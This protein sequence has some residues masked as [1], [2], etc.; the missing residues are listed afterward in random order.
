MSI[1]VMPRL[2][3]ARHLSFPGRFPLYCM[4]ND[5]RC[6]KAAPA[7]VSPGPL[8]LTR[9]TS[10]MAQRHVRFALPAESESSS[11]SSS[12]SIRNVERP[13]LGLSIPV[14]T[15]ICSQPSI[16]DYVSPASSSSTLVE[17][18]PMLRPPVKREAM[19]PSYQGLSAD[20]HSSLPELPYLPLSPL[21]LW[22]VGMRE[23][24]HRLLAEPLDQG[25]NWD[26]RFKEPDV[27]N[28]DALALAATH[29][30][31]PTIRLHCPA[32]PEYPYIV[33]KP[34]R[35]RALWCSE[36]LSYVAVGDV[37]MGLFDH[38]RVRLTEGPLTRMGRQKAEGVDDARRWRCA[39]PSAAGKGPD[40]RRV[41]CLG[42]AYIFA[43][44]IPADQDVQVGAPAGQGPVYTVICATAQ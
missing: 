13:V 37:F 42:D 40:A 14:P 41:D 33:I 1:F 23:S 5:S 24:I 12:P 32:I 30:S 39:H 27:P 20:N 44:L 38:L 3:N 31:V 36:V 9:P 26:M 19:Y 7:C 17:N 15:A 35:E 29:P 22:H 18:F 34:Y 28:T 11:D 2:S 4:Y 21:P 6:Y 10:S 8:P 16:A 43:G 25:L